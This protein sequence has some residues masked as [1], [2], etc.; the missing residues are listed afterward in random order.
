MTCPG[1]PE[2]RAE[3][4]RG[5]QVV[6]GRVEP[7]E[8]KIPLFLCKLGFNYEFRVMKNTFSSI[9]GPGGEK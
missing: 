8:E 3:A 7:E 2:H 1:R 5:E 4:L 9:S 6:K